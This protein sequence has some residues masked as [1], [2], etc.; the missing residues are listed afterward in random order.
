MNPDT[1][2]DG[3]VAL[4]KWINFAPISSSAESST[5]YFMGLAQKAPQ[6]FPRA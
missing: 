6:T 5:P 1:S 4:D 3:S 2:F